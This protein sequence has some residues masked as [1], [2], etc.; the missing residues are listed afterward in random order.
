[1]NNNNNS[2]NNNKSEISKRTI[3]ESKSTVLY[4]LRNEKKDDTKNIVNEPK[5]IVLNNNTKYERSYNND[6]S[7]QVIK[8]IKIIKEKNN[9]NDFPKRVPSHLNSVSQSKKQDKLSDID[10]R[11][12]RRYDAGTFKNSIRNKYKNQ[13]K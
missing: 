7:K 13:K 3:N 5:T 2:N 11:R 8:D 6:S 1:M 10:D 9:T 12:T 4:R